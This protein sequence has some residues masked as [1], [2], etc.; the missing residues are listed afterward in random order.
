[1]HLMLGFTL[2]GLMLM[3]KGGVM[4]PAVWLLRLAH[5]EVLLA[6]FMLQ[7]VFG[8]GFWILPRPAGPLRDRP[9]MAAFLL[10]N[11]GVWLVSAGST[12]TDWSGMVPLGRLCETGAV[13]LFI[14][15]IWP[16]VRSLQL[17]RE[18]AAIHS[19]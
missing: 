14:Y 5:Q 2:G 18:R 9:M 13:V 16:R 19:S 3:H 8:V 10:I 12:L 17:A 4:P 11:A 6:G 1:M 7:L 15:S